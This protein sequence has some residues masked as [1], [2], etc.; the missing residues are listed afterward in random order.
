MFQGEIFGWGEYENGQTLR[1][2]Y[3]EWICNTFSEL[4]HKDVKATRN[5]YRYDE[6][7]PVNFHSYIDNRPHLMLVVELENGRIIAGYSEG[8]LDKEVGTEGKYG[9]LFAVN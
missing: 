9:L 6:A 1:Q 7:N 3:I 4:T 5:L 8:E 2:Q